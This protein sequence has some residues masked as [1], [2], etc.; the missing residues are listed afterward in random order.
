MT[1]NLP[2][3]LITDPANPKAATNARIF[4]TVTAQAKNLGLCS[5]HMR[6]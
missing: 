1:K 5:P 3:P 6:G 2:K 4:N